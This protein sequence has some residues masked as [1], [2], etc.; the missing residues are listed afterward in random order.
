VI[1]V[2]TYGALPDDASDDSV[3]IQRAIDNAPD[4]S[5][6]YFPRGTYLVAHVNIYNRHGLTLLG[7]GSTLSVLKRS[8]SYPNIFESSGS[9]DMLVTQLGFDANGIVAYGGFVFYDAK[10]ITITKT[11]FFDANQQPVGQYDRYSWVFG[12]GSVPSEDILISDNLVEDLQL[13]VDY[14]LRVRIEGNT[15]VRPVATAGIGVFTVNDNTT[16]QGYTIQK[17]TIVDPVVSAGGIVLHLDPPSSS[18]STMKSFRILDN[19]IVYTKYISGSHASA[20][21]LGTGD[22]SQATRG[23][24]FDDIA[25]Q[26]NLIYKDP[27]SQYDF[28]DINGI[29]FGNSSATANFKFNNT[30][31]SNNRIY[32]NNRWGLHITDIREKGVNYVEGNNL[33]SAIS[34]DIMPPSVPTAL[35]TTYISA[36][37]IDL[38]WNASV[39]NIGVSKYRIYRNGVGSSFSTATSYADKNLQPGVSYTYAVTAIDLS[40][41][42]SSQSYPVT[43]KI[44]KTA[45]PISATPRAPIVNA[46]TPRAPIVNAVTLTANPVSIPAGGTLT[47]AWTAI[48]SPTSTDWIGLYQ[49]GAA[50]TS[51]LNWIYVSCSKTPGSP[52]AS[53]SCPF[54][55]PASLPAGT[56]ELRLFAN[57]SGVTTLATSNALKQTKRKR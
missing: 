1:D 50:N 20:I 12:R 41:V 39:D 18:Y 52:R 46:V 28:G 48:A 32:Y 42:E 21:R 49:R 29:I 8:G 55:V 3:A 36:Y 24:V 37:Q 25:I 30:N 35:T 26:N 6:I 2:R 7:D 43:V 53:G 34:S 38:A 14:G 44:S 5:T 11:H 57:D 45:N 51:Y 33:G 23:N 4:N 19:H 13:E 40:G 27:G 9:T 22:N 56:Y 10:R 15:V 17:N 47:S 54:V 31:V 16:A